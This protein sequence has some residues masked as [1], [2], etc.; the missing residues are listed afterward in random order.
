[1]DALLAGVEVQWISFSGSPAARFPHAE[2][3]RT[4]VLT[5]DERQLVGALVQRAK[6]AIAEA[7]RLRDAAPAPLTADEE[8]RLRA[9]DIAVFEGRFICEARPAI[10]DAERAA[11]EK[12]LSGPVPDELM[13]LW[14][15]TFGGALSYELYADFG[16]VRGLPV[17]FTELFFP[18]SSHYHDLHG[19]IDHEMELACDVAAERRE[20]APA[21]LRMLPFGGFEYLDRVYV[22]VAPGPDYGTVWAWR[23]ALPPAWN[24]PLRS[25]ALTRVAADVRVLFR[26]LHITMA[27]VVDPHGDVVGFE[28]WL[29]P[30]RAGGDEALADRVRQLHL[31]AAVES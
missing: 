15:R 9:Y 18:R 19:W 23:K 17:S 3:M 8:D 22:D 20:R 21:R 26:K 12:K 7:Q 11:I 30:L 10:T 16:S 5:P 4:M 6:D 14:K 2:G 13:A 28:R 25:D 31:A 27:R 29:E 1:M 24:G